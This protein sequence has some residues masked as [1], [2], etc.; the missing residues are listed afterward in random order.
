M[1]T[2][3]QVAHRP[4]RRFPNA[5]RTVFQPEVKKC[6]YCKSK[7]RST[8]NISIN[9][10][11]QTMDGALNVRAYSWRCSNQDCPCPDVR[12]RA[13]RQLWKVSLPKSGYG[14]DVVAH[15]GWQHDK[16]YRQFGEIQEDLQSR[17]I[18]ISERHVG[19]LYRQY[20]SLLGGLADQRLQHLKKVNELHGGVVWA[21]DALQPD[22][23]GTL[24]YVLYEAISETTVAAAWLDKRDSDHI[25]GWLKPYADLNFTVLATLSD[26]EDAEIKALRI[27]WSN[28]PH[29]MCLT[30]FLGDCTKPIKQADRMLKATLRKAM[31]PLPPVPGDE[32][33]AKAGPVAASPVLSEPPAQPTDHLETNNSKQTSKKYETNPDCNSSL[34]ASDSTTLDGDSNLPSSD[35]KSAQMALCNSQLAGCAT[36]L[37]LA[38]GN[39]LASS[40]QFICT[41]MFKNSSTEAFCDLALVG[42]IPPNNTI[43]AAGG[44]RASTTDTI[45]GSPFYEGDTPKQALAL[46]LASSVKQISHQAAE[47]TNQTTILGTIKTNLGSQ[48]SSDELLTAYTTSFTASAQVTGQTLEHN[49]HARS[50]MAEAQAS[51]QA[52]APFVTIATQATQ[53]TDEESVKETT[54]FKQT[55]EV[56]DINQEELE[57]REIEHL[58]R[59]SFQNALSHTSRYPSIFGGLAG[60]QQLE[61]IVRAMREQL[62]QE[63]ENYLHR[64]FRQAEQGLKSAAEQAK[65]VRCANELR[66][67]LTSIFFKPFDASR[68]DDLLPQELD[69]QEVKQEALDLLSLADNNAGNLTKTFIRTSRSLI[70]KWEE[71]LFNCYDV[72]L[73]PPTNAVLESRFNCLRS[74]QRR[75][76]G[77]KKT[78]ELRRSAHLQLLLYAETK[79][80]LLEQFVL[81]P[82]EAYSNARVCLDF[83]EERQRQL[84]RLSRK[85]YETASILIAKY[86]KLG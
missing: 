57:K 18:Q 41:S 2:T 34:P 56:N 79:E 32:N 33:S 30:H 82:E 6:P 13:Q 61:G 12:Y 81:V 76:S 60:Y 62:P 68:N 55:T 7:L 64:L 86:L 59:K 11:V 8:G 71:S 73:L 15:I 54:E 78:N 20:L 72:S 17:N 53:I 4:S 44:E 48:E 40:E 46:D 70:S 27:L 47:G 22:K 9:R 69:G 75:I 26:G 25:I 5:P 28:S 67:Q 84:A 23:D 29:Q 36:D 14:L 3:S 80:Q 31:G 65:Q 49:L 39:S 43:Q 10:E 52:Q 19:R 16:K 1:K 50:T 58:F 37:R 24:L 63:E 66:S 51:S 85:P 35:N 74:A 45:E 38:E 42:D 83:A 77:R 21:L